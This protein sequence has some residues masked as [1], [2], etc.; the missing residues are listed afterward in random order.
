[1]ILA[2]IRTDART[3]RENDLVHT[4]VTLLNA[5]N[6]A[7]VVVVDQD[8]APVGIIS[9]RDV[10]RGLRDHGFALAALPAREL[11]TSALE[12]C[13]ADDSIDS[14]AHRMIG[15]GFRHMPVVRHGRLIAVL[16]VLDVLKV[17][18]TEIEFENL[19]MRQA[20]VG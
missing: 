19:R 5:D 20:M 3:V 16:S 2:R 13:T 14:V 8:G 7:A 10:V 4:V 12:C 17:H 11:M 15:G 18:V 6:A 1:M 9:E